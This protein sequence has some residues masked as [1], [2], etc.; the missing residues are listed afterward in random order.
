MLFDGAVK[1]QDI[2]LKNETLLVVL[3][4]ANWQNQSII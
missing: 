3:L 1:H 4:L 2:F